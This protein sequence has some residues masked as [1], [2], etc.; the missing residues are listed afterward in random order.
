MAVD[1]NAD[2]AEAIRRAANRSAER[3]CLRIAKKNLERLDGSLTNVI[4]LL[5]SS[6]EVPDLEATEQIT[7][8]RSEPDLRCSL[9]TAAR[10]MNKLEEAVKVLALL[11]Y[12]AEVP[13]PS[14]I[15]KHLQACFELLWHELREANSRLRSIRKSISKDRQVSTDRIAH[16]IQQTERVMRAARDHRGELKKQHDSI[17]PENVS[18]DRVTKIVIKPVSAR[19]LLELASK[20]KLL[21]T[22]FGIKRA[23]CDPATLR[24]NC[25][26]VLP[27]PV[28]GGGQKK[29]LF[30]PAELLR[31]L[32]TS[33]NEWIE[34]KLSKL[35][36]ENVLEVA[37]FFCQRKPTN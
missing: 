11:G 5:R 36:D 33:Q 28:D 9:R 14:E 2:V 3:A 26:P 21:I 8:N 16:A 24:R 22:L 18:R 19:E 6:S 1:S 25:G 12:D 10:I 17:D 4:K 27:E 37:E 20:R 23:L 31:N 35:V 29:N 13:E 34:R 32:V 15:P 7:T 30:D